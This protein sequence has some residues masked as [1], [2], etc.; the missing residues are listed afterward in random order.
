M[1]GSWGQAFNR[2]KRSGRGAR[3][4]RIQISGKRQCGRDSLTFRQNK[5]IILLKAPG[6]YFLLTVIAGIDKL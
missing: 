3:K 5:K 1:A 6:I 4:G 2:G